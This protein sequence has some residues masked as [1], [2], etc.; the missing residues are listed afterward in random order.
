[1]ATCP[2]RGLRARL[3]AV[4]CKRGARRVV[5]ARPWTPARARGR[6]AGGAAARHRRLATRAV[7]PCAVRLV[8]CALCALCHASPARLPVAMRG[9]LSDVRLGSK[10][11]SFSSRPHRARRCDFAAQFD[12]R[13]DDQRIAHGS[14]FPRS[15]LSAA[16]CLEP[17]IRGRCKR[18]ARRLAGRLVRVERHALGCWRGRR[19]PRLAWCTG[20]AWRAGRACFVSGSAMDDS[21][22]IGFA[23]RIHGVG[24]LRRVLACGT[25]CLT[26]RARH[27]N[28]LRASRCRARSRARRAPNGLGARHPVF[29]LGVGMLACANARARTLARALTRRGYYGCDRWPVRNRFPA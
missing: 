4:D 25:R 9:R 8:S 11:L 14:R 22:T 1:M 15:T 16:A 6:C 28:Y 29:N 13:T 18:G 21:G 20:L 12:S 2:S 27:A 5:V 24:L 19:S 7:A 17:S 23:I 26:Q 3:R 10:L